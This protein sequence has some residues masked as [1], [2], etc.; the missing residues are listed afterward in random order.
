VISI[1]ILAAGRSERFGTNKLLQILNGKPLVLHA[2]DAAKQANVGDVILVTGQDGDEVAAAAGDGP[3]HVVHNL[4][5]ENGIGSSIACGVAACR[6]QSDA[7]IVLLADQP[8]VDSSHLRRLVAEWSGADNEIVATSFDESRGPPVLFPADAF[9]ALC[10]L[11]GDDG[12]KSLF[13]DPRF[14]I[15]SVEFSPAGI[16][17]DTPD[18]LRKLDRQPDPVSFVGEHPRDQFD[19]LLRS[20]EDGRRCALVTII[21]IVDTAA[22]NL[23][24]HMVVSDDGQYAGS[25]SSGCVDANVATFALEA[26]D[27]GDASRVR[28]GAGSCFVDIALPC[29]GG[30]DLLI[31]PDPDPAAIRAVCA[32]LDERRPCGLVIG[33]AGVQFAEDASATAAA[34]DELFP[35]SYQPR[36]RLVLAGRG[37]ELTS[38]CRIGYAC[39][40][41]VSVM[42]PSAA[43]VAGCESLGA[44][45]THLDSPRSPPELGAD[46]STAIVLLFHDHDWERGILD[47]ALKSDAF[48]IGA[49]GSRKTQAARLEMLKA[50]GISDEAL[51]RING[52]I[53]LVP[54]MRNAPMLAISTLAEIIDLFNRQ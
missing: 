39:G 28:L 27:T 41:D 2:V 20:V 15:R 25:V 44:S 51:A 8:L 23:G 38:F 1:L 36:L 19:F 53:G 24:T 45:A 5:F 43:D 32:G 3:A 30:I 22:R 33:E 48:Y 17:V 52:P 42:S 49:L 26:L 12:G 50:S 16:D 7:I 54:S 31:V 6:D 47:A 18:D 46:T 21:G 10:E 14:D 35:V 4:L 9:S 34:Q 29:G 13:V 40:F 11:S 37:A